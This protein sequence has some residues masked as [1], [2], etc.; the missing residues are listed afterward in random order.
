MRVQAE[1]CSHRLWDSID[2]LM[3]AQARTNRF[4]D[5]CADGDGKH[6]RTKDRT[7]DSAQSPSW[8]VRFRHWNSHQKKENQPELTQ[9][10]SS[11]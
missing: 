8:I 11:H 4:D 1:N 2:E 7:A 10:F 3:R 5:K 9:Q 6:S